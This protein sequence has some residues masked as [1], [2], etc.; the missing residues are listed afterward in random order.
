M[1]SALVPGSSDPGSSPGR[2]HCRCCVLGQDT[3]FS[4]CPSLPKSINGYRRIVG[5]NVTNCW[6]MTCDGLVSRPRGVEILLAASCYGN[7]DKL[8]PDEPAGSKGFTLSYWE[9]EMFSR[10]N[11]TL[12]THTSSKAR[13]RDEYM[14]PDFP[15]SQ[16]IHKRVQQRLQ[17]N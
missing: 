5:E 1:V 10:S 2:G 13:Q 9:K 6:G 15:H 3:L 8:R 12:T 4:Q 7:R 16:T 14:T 11:S 17:I